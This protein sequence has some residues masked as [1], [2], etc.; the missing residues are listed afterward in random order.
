MCDHPFENK[1][2]KKKTTHIKAEYSHE[3]VTECNDDRLFEP[4]DVGHF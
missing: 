3:D 2:T 4:D 1:Q